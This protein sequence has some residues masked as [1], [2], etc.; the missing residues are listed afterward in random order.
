MILDEATAALDEKTEEKI[1]SE[2][3]KSDKTCFIITHRR[4]M[5]RYC[6]RVIE[7]GEDNR[8]TEIFNKTEE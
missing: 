8:I 1:L 2:I 5:L 4:S 7:I 6:D 3:S